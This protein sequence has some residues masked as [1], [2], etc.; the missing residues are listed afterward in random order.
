M[1]NFINDASAIIVKPNDQFFSWLTSESIKNTIPKE[2]YD[3]LEA[4]EPIAFRKNGTV[5]TIPLIV[6]KLSEAKRFVEENSDKILSTELSRWGLDRSVLPPS[7]AQDLVN[8]WFDITYHS[9]V[10]SLSE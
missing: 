9:Q 1:N 4:Y 7:K 5:I 2:T 8:Q 10:F 6:A 3:V